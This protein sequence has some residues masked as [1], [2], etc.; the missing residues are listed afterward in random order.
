MS[1]P[2]IED[3][4]RVFTKREAAERLKVSTSTIDR[5]IA[6]GELRSVRPGRHGVVVTIPARSLR[7]YIYGS[8]M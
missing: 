8:D 3:D 2:L 7:D 5:L 4:L 1:A 6:R